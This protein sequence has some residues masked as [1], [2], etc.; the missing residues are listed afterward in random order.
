M[1]VTVGTYICLIEPGSWAGYGCASPPLAFE[2]KYS[3]PRFVSRRIDSD[4]GSRRVADLNRSEVA[5]DAIDQQIERG[6]VLGFPVQPAPPSAKTGIHR[7]GERPEN[8]ADESY[9]DQ[10]SEETI[11]RRADDNARHAGKSRNGEVALHTHRADTLTRR[12]SITD[13]VW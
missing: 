6:R 3:D 1:S 8:K 11:D 13:A 9:Q 10:E 7:S 12:D 5:E 4:T 2:R